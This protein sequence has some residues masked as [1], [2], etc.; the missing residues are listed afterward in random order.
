MSSKTRQ[1]QI[2][3]SYLKHIPPILDFEASSLSDCS[4]PISAGLIVGGRIHHWLIRPKPEWIDWS[5]ESQAI[6][7]MKRSF[8]I[9][10]GLDVKHVYNEMNHALAGFDV[11][12]SDNP[13]WESRWLSQLGH[14]DV[15]V[16]DVSQLIPHHYK[17]SWKA[18]FEQQFKEHLLERHRADHDALALALTLQHIQYNEQC[19]L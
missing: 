3:V 9:E 17:S 11:V 16:K 18:I 14:F 7:G 4:Y 5:L 15:E 1:I 13:D 6:H 2:E 8:L 10:N 19:G 12:Y